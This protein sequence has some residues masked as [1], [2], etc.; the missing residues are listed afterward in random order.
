LLL[1]NPMF[2]FYR[3]RS[4]QWLGHISTRETSIS[5]EIWIEAT[6]DRALRRL[7]EDLDENWS[8][9]NALSLIRCQIRKDGSDL[10]LEWLVDLTT[11]FVWSPVNA[12]ESESFSNWISCFLLR[13]NYFR[14]C[15]NAP[16]SARPW[17]HRSRN[18]TVINLALLLYLALFPSFCDE[19]I[20]QLFKRYAAFSIT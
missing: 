17:R 6:T 1:T 12:H 9:T 13:R 10:K 20:F 18:F 7:P 14:K 15:W 4:R 11:C 2:S 8:D 16:A 3:S 5:I 19:S